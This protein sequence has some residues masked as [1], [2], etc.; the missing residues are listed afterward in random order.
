MVIRSVSEAL[1]QVLWNEISADPVTL[2]IVGAEQAIVFSNP[3]QTALDSANRLS[4]WLYQVV[5]DEFVKNQPMIRGSNPDPADA[6]GRY[7]DD[8]P[9][10]ALNLMYLLTPFAQ[11]GE[12]DHLLLGKS[13]L[14]LY[15]N[16]STL[17]VDQAASV[18][19][20]LRITLHRHTLEELTRI[21]DALKEPYRL[22]VCYQ[23]KVTRLDSSRQPANA[24][25]VELSGDYGPVPESE[26][27]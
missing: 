7:R 2:P 9:P 3:T 24:R 1:R 5:E 27:V 15:D 16:A 23:V 25:V 10:M 14:A 8:F 18:A 12:S 22:S 26:P 20:E 21:W 17:M 19:E 11:S 4:L 6:R 13:M